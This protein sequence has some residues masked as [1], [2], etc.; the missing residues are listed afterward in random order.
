LNGS[1]HFLTG[2]SQYPLQSSLVGNI[3]YD[4]EMCSPVTRNKGREKR[5][6]A[7]NAL[8]VYIVGIGQ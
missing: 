3:L 6:K 5:E 8:N 1:I 7:L 2:H 4:K